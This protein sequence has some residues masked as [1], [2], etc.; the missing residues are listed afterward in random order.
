MAES[1]DITLS[2]TDNATA[3]IKKSAGEMELLRDRVEQTSKSTAKGSESIQKFA[4][5]LGAG[6]ITDSAAQLKELSEAGKGAMEAL[7]GGG[8]GALALKAGL[9]GLAAIAGY[10]VGEQIAEWVF[11]TKKFTEELIRAT[12]QSRKLG[13][14]MQAKETS[15]INQDVA[16]IQKFGTT[17]GGEDEAA[18]KARLEIE[19]KGKAGQVELAKA[20]LATLESKRSI[21]LVSQEEVEAAKAN[22]ETLRASKKVYDDI[23]QTRFSEGAAAR[24]EWEKQQEEQQDAEKQALDNRKKLTEAFFKFQ[25]DMAKQYAKEEEKQQK[26]KEKATLKQKDLE[27]KAASEAIK[28]TQ[29]EISDLEKVKID[30]NTS[31]QGR[32]ERVLSRSTDAGG[33]ESQQLANSKKQTMILEK[34]RE[35]EE[36]IERHLKLMAEKEDKVVEFSGA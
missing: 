3:V 32:E 31:L 17:M 23:L 34:Q 4:N 19:Q 11:Q 20:T 22:L 9:V 12:E 27:I 5:V 1:I 21:Y 18:L 10:K 35:L 6:W 14:E 36:K 8:S 2:A 33:L 15:R 13:A 30:T 29:K 28:A 25:E 24:R 26:A 16:D 7:K